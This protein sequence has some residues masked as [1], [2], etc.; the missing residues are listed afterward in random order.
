MTD[1]S[2]ILCTAIAIFYLLTVVAIL[3]EKKTFQLASSLFILVAYALLVGSRD[4]GHFA[5]ARN[6]LVMFQHLDSFERLLTIY[7]KDY[8][9]A[10][11]MFFINTL[12]FEFPTFLLALTLI[13]AALFFFG[14]YFLFRDKPSTLLV[15]SFLLVCTSS[16][17]F[18]MTNIL[19]Q[20]LAEA[21]LVFALGCSQMTRIGGFFGYMS[22]FFAHHR[23]A[24]PMVISAFFPFKHKN[25]LGL[26]CLIGAGL[27]HGFGFLHFL[28]DLDVSS[29]TS[30]LT[31]YNSHVHPR[32][33]LKI[34]VTLFMML[35]GLWLCFRRNDSWLRQLIF[36]KALFLAAEILVYGPDLQATR[37]HYYCAILDTILLGGFGALLV[38]QKRMNLLVATYGVFYGMYVYT[39]PSIIAQISF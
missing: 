16:V 22:G 36:M 2:L 31:R 13:Q 23:S 34:I 29:L 32:L 11:I 9:F 10:A 38:S 5:D 28:V 25:Y 27:L 14:L 8:T 39:H 30:S 12:G 35:V 3:S 21:F 18:G 17:A 33:I 26:Y 6:Y 19:R 20:G 7:H 1:G 37:L 15:T 4:S 24:A